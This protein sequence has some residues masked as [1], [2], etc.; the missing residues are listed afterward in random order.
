M[1]DPS[2][3]SDSK[4]AQLKFWNSTSAVDQYAFSKRPPFLYPAERRLLG[5]Y[6]DRWPDVRMLDIGIGAGRTSHYFAALAGQYAGIDF[7]PN[8]IEACRKR[9]AGRWPGAMFQ[10]GDAT[11]LKEHADDSY[12]LVLFSF[13]GIDCLPYP[14]RQQ[15]LSEMQ[16]VCR[17]GGRIVFSSHNLYH[18]SRI[19]TFHFHAHPMRLRE[20]ICRWWQVQ[21]RNPPVLEAMAGSYCEYDDGNIGANRLMFIRPEVQTA[22][23]ADL[24]L[25]VT[26]RYANDGRELVTDEDGRNPD[27]SWLYYFCRKP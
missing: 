5:L 17:P 13:N 22:D 7:A 6:R 1:A 23:L 24:G 8:M 20:E 10:E 26:G 19:P 27:I 16:R 15:A 11:A 4:E 18:I 3:S 12:D 2:P 9:F 14:Q 21:R 25:E